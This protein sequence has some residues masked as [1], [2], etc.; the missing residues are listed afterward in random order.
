[1]PVIFMD[2][3]LQRTLHG[4]LV[5]IGYDKA[6][7][8]RILQYPRSIEVKKGVIRHSPG[9][10]HHLHVR[11]DCLSATDPCVAPKK[12]WIAARVAPVRL[13]LEPAAKGERRQ[14]RTLLET[15]PIAAHTTERETLAV[16]APP[17]TATPIVE[18]DRMPT[19]DPRVVRGQEAESRRTLPTAVSMIERHWL[20]LLR[21]H[22]GDHGLT[23]PLPPQP[24]GS[25]TSERPA[26]SERF[27]PSSETQ[28]DPSDAIQ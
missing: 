5:Q 26:R 23:S 28:P 7:R 14:R 3:A 10:H 8:S 1:V 2:Y 15:A 13:A 20:E 17:E 9:H 22:R 16:L 24:V 6:L 11:F 12:V 25:R 18:N 4:H 21:N 27:G 19:D